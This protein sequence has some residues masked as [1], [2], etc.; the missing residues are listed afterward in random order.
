MCAYGTTLTHY[1]PAYLPLLQT[2]QGVIT[3]DPLPEGEV[4]QLPRRLLCTLSQHPCGGAPEGSSQRH[5]EQVRCQRLDYELCERRATAGTMVYF[6][7]FLV[8]YVCDL[9]AAVL[10]GK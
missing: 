10:F 2:E 3:K 1:P 4:R 9:L 5:F 7:F 6:T 8:L